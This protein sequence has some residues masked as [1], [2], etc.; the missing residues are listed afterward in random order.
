VLGKDLGKYSFREWRFGI[1]P[2]RKGE[3]QLMVRATAQSGEIQPL[4][5]TWNPAGY[6]RNVIETTKISVA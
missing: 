4:E 3:L 1:T 5:A 6:A 2:S